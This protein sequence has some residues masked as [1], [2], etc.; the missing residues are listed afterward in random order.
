MTTAKVPIQAPPDPS[1][2]VNA[3]GTDYRVDILMFNSDG[4]LRQISS[5]SFE[6]ISF[7][8]MHTTPFLFGRLTLNNNENSELNNII[9]GID[10][11]DPDIAK[12]T[13]ELGRYNSA[14][15]KY[16]ADLSA[17]EVEFKS[18]EVKLGKYQ[19]D[20]GMYQAELQKYNTELNQNISEYQWYTQRY[21]LFYNQYLSGLTQA[22][23][24]QQAE[25]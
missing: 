11:S 3:D 8:T 16:Q 17:F 12:F 25:A 6:S 14:L 19:A 20:V 18:Y 22:Q 7:E 10:I 23:P 5:Q 13:Q 24:A 15:S 1:F 4:E 21:Q 2:R 9:R